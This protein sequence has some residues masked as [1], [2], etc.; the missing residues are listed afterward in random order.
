MAT[1]SRYNPGFDNEIALNG[2]YDLR[3]PTQKMNI[4]V[5]KRYEIL[6]ESVQSI[7]KSADGGTR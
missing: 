4:F 1:F 6:E 2:K 7:L 5:A 3:L